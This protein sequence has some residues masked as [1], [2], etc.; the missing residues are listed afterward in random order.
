LPV[1][2][3]GAS[4]PTCGKIRVLLRKSGARTTAAKIP[5]K[6]YGKPEDVAE[7]VCFLASDSSNYIT[8][9]SMDVNG[10]LV[11]D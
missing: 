10:G 4:P 5:L 9:A 6:H 3:L 8:G 2:G 7:V 11:M 1:W